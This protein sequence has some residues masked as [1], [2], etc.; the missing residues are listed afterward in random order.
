MFYD[1][2]SVMNSIIA[3]CFI[4]FKQSMLLHIYMQ[5]VQFINHIRE[6][7]PNIIILCLYIFATKKRLLLPS[8]FTIYMKV[9]FTYYIIKEFL[10]LL[11]F[12]LFLVLHVYKIYFFLNLF[13]LLLLL[14]FATI[15]NL[16][17][18]Y[19]YP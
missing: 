18:K 17:I 7:M 14:L 4:F 13:L 9:Y 3:V 2:M 16:P 5:I 12:S 8:L 11:P 1:F 10:S 6:Y 15:C 19:I